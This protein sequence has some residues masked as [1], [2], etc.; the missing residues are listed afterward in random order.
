MKTEKMRK[1]RAAKRGVVL[2][3][4]I[5]VLLFL[6]STIALAAPPD[7]MSKKGVVLRWAAFL[8]QYRKPSVDVVML[9]YSWEELEPQEGVFNVSDLER[10]L[11]VAKEDGKRLA[12]CLWDHNYGSKGIGPG[13]PDWVGCARIVYNYSRGQLEYPVRWDPVYQE[14]WANFVWEIA[15]RYGDSFEFVMIVETTLPWQAEL[16]PLWEAAGYNAQVYEQALETNALLF[17]QAFPNS[18]VLQSINQFT[19]TTAKYFNKNP[20]DVDLM[21]DLADYCY[22][23]NVGFANPGLKA[24]DY[25]AQTYIDWPIFET[26]ENLV[27]EA[28]LISEKALNDGGV[29]TVFDVVDKAF[30]IGK[31]NYL[32][33]PSIWFNRTGGPAMIDYAHSLFFPATP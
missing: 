22:S 20:Q 16:R 2:L 1:S 11:G 33:V 19:G 4:G 9:D 3:V 10:R 5:V 24:V 6:S 29:S 15:T 14:K 25:A 32:I 18:A 30:T 27:P 21:W 8:S 28:L 7:Q 23:L 17:S 31:I 12:L 26:Y 13:L